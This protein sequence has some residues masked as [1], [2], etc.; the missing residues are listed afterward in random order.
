LPTGY[1]SACS[2]VSSLP[3][4][5][6]DIANAHNYIQGN[7]GAGTTLIDNHVRYAETIAR[8]GPYAG[9]WDTYG[10]YWGNTWF[11]PEEMTF[12]LMDLR[13]GNAITGGAALRLGVPVI[14]TP[15]HIGIPLG[16]ARRA[17]DEI[18]GQAVEKE[19]GF[20][21][22]PLATHPHFQF[23]LGK[24]ELELAA[25]RALALQVFSNLW[26]Q[27]GAGGTPLPEQQAQ[28]RAASAYITEVAQSVA[29][30]AF[31]AA[32]GGA[33]LD[34]NPLQRCFRDAYAVGQHFMVSQSSY[35]ALGQFKLGQPDANPML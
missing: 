8:S 9:L 18:T 7:G 17:L 27:A 31:Q 33:L 35:R 16:I 22:S 30:V 15:F 28:A 24:A 11:V 2:A 1:R 5:G 25:A 13:L 23:A 19:R 6:G 14:A 12:R 21:T 32:G 34:T 29:T 10:E 4:D 3:R 20:P 26:D